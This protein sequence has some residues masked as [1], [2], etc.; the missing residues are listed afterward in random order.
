ME[1]V[2]PR[3]VLD[4]P[5]AMRMF[6]SQFGVATIGQLVAVGISERAIGRARQ[7]GVLTSVLPGVVELGDFPPTFRQRAMAAQLF[8]G[9]DSFLDGTTAGRYYGLRGMPTRPVELVTSRRRRGALPDWLRATFSTWIDRTDVVEHEDGLRIAAPAKMLLGLAG[10]FNDPQFERAAEDAWHLRL[11]S[12]AQAAEYLDRVGAARSTRRGPDAPLARRRCRT[13]TPGPERTGDQGCSR[14]D[15]CRPAGAS[16]AAS[17]DAGQR[18]ADPPRPRLARRDARLRTWALVVA[19]RRPRSAGRPAAATRLRG[20]R[21]ARRV[22]RRIGGDE[23]R[24]CRRRD[25]HDLPPAPSTVPHRVTH[26][27]GEP[28]RL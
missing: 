1:H 22:L 27:A 11:V 21:M 5:E 19:W 10:R 18:C 3:G 28:W 15:R 2:Y 14:R 12:P 24:G 8:G 13:A 16:T 23:P 20:R 25:R 9:P 7:R 4:R 17:V 26:D 6:A